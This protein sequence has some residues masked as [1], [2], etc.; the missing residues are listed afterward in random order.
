MVNFAA[1]GTRILQAG[2]YTKMAR[3]MANTCTKMAGDMAN[4]CSTRDM[5]AARRHD[6]R[7]QKQHELALLAGE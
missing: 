5:R 3:D 7:L 1:Q 6:A 4:T 2:A